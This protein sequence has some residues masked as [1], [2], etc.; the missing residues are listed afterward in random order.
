MKDCQKATGTLTELLKVR[1]KSA[2]Q[3]LDRRMLE[4]DLERYICAANAHESNG[5][6]SG[7]QLYGVLHRQ[8][9]D[10]CRLFTTKWSLDP[11][12]LYAEVPGLERLRRLAEPAAALGK[13]GKVT[14]G[15]CMAVLAAFAAGILAGAANL[16]FHLIGG[17]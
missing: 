15:I 6:P 16:G 5:V 1:F 17:R 3:F 8:A 14:I 7:S 10:R 4:V 2:R 13:T 12:Q 11:A 9:D